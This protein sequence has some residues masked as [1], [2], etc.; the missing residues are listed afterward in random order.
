MQMHPRGKKMRIDEWKPSCLRAM[1]DSSRIHR[2][3]NGTLVALAMFPNLFQPL[4]RR[5]EPN[6]IFS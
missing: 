2:I 5:P 1:A 6:N 4:A 3:L